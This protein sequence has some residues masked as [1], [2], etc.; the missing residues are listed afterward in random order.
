M[1]SSTPCTTA[2][3]NITPLLKKLHKPETH[4]L[5]IAED[6]S[7]AFALIFEENRL[8]NIQAATFLTLLSTTS[9]DKDANVIAACA[10]RMRDA[11]SLMD[12]QQLQT[13]IHQRARTEGAYYGGLCDIVGTGGSPVQTYNISTT[14]SL[15]ASS[16]LLMSKHGNRAQTSVSGAADILSS[17]APTPPN[18]LASNAENIPTIYENSNYAFLFA[19]NFHPGMRFAAPLRREMGIRTIFNL[20]GPLAHPIDELI[21]ARVV[22]VT[23][24]SL[25][26][27]FAQ[28]LAISSK[29]KPPGRRKAM[30]VCARA[31]LDEISCEG[32]TDCW[33]LYE[34]EDGQIGIRQFTLEPEHFGFSTH[35][36]TAIRGGN[37][38]KDNAMI[39]MQMLRGEL[40]QDDPILQVV[41]MNAAAMLVVSGACEAQSSH[42]G[43]GDDGS[44]IQEKGPGGGRWK[45]GVRRAR[46][47]VQSGAALKSLR[48]F[49]EI[50]NS[51][52]GK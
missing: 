36:L 27:T 19:P 52:G 6:I 35:P 9:R 34:A 23:E 44:V 40:N 24:T 30:V 25:G 50:S 2:A 11:A 13:I 42:M 10:A 18:L 20:L 5:A 7:A 39:L 48:A 38:P 31:G 51:F 45:E 26:A 37:A 12:L 43:A 1:S 21:E 49:I 32:V 33:M 46:W 29:Q 15:I 8:S 22:G 47:A 41:L 28:A 3:I 17:I 16:F 4:G 14:A